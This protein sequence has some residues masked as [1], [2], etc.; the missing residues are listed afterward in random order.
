MNCLQPERYYR[1]LFKHTNNESTKI[2]DDNYFFKVI[3]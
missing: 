3:R 1:V 2:Y